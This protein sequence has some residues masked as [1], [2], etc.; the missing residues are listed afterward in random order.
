MVVT[1]CI[2]LFR[3]GA[4]IHNGIFVQNKIF[5]ICGRDMRKA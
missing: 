3:I 1:Y 4:D 2:K 5:E